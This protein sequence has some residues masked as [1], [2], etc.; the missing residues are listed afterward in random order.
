M[1][2]NKKF[3]LIGIAIAAI[4]IAVITIRP[5][6]EKHWDATEKIDRF[7][8]ISNGNSGDTFFSE[9]FFSERLNKDIADK[10]TVDLFKLLQF[11]FQNDNL[12]D[13]FSDVLKYLISMYGEEKAKELLEI[14]KKFTYYEMGLPGEK[15]FKRQQPVSASEA[16]DLL[17][18]IKNHRENFFGKELADNLF[19]EEDRMYKYQILS[20][21]I[22]KDPDTYGSE[23]EKEIK[24]LQKNIGYES[25]EN[26]G[27]SE[28]DKYS[29]KLRLY[30]KDLSELN[31]E[32][33]KELMRKFRREIF[34]P[35]EASRLEQLDMHNEQEALRAKGIPDH[36]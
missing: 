20:N 34:T 27:M 12:D 33:Q 2:K 14:Y 6:A 26:S 31:A 15:F 36:N 29:L 22:V 13:H 3:L 21:E 30:K 8:G 17:S 28:M 4:V 16:L 1:T 5:G 9:Q 23:K 32:Q 11:K 25:D 7:L 24:E 18:E 10:Y 19:G 35:D